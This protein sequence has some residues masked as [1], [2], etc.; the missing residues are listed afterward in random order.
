MRYCLISYLNNSETMDRRKC[1]PFL[2]QLDTLLKIILDMLSLPHPPLPAASWLT[3]GRLRR[4]E[5]AALSAWPRVEDLPAV[6]LTG[7]TG[8]FWKN[9]NAK[10]FGVA[11]DDVQDFKSFANT[12]MSYRHW[13]AFSIRMRRYLV[14]WLARV[15]PNFTSNLSTQQWLNFFRQPVNFFN[16]YN[17]GYFMT[18]AMTI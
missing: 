7:L 15:Y 2:S 4:P 8:I 14:R 9:L 1:L 13:T 17:S 16:P 11:A 6:Q 10:L 18:F 3:R 12:Q 5:V